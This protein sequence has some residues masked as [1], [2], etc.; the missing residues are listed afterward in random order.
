[1]ALLVA[2]VVTVDDSGVVSYAPADPDDSYAG[3]LFRA[4]VEAVD[5]FTVASSGVVPAD[6]ERVPLLRY[7]ATRSNAVA[8]RVTTYLNA[9]L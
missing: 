4:E 9:T 3:A 8:L 1:M 6:S 7:Y 5:A 2:G